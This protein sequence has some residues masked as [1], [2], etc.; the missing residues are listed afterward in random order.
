MPNPPHFSDAQWEEIR[1]ITL[2]EADE[3]RRVGVQKEAIAPI[4]IVRAIKQVGG[5]C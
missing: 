2:A 4:A 1:R 5:G 3:L